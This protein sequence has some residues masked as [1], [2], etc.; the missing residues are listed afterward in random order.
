MTNS[1]VLRQDI[2]VK[3]LEVL[4]KIFGPDSPLLEFLKNRVLI[5][6]GPE[7][8]KN[9]TRILIQIAKNPTKW[10]GIGPNGLV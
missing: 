1:I 9:S 6:L 2:N 4:T 7:R 5:V 3:D 8:S 10:F